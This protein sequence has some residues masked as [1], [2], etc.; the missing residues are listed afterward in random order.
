MG[1]VAMHMF[2]LC[3]F[4]LAGT[5]KCGKLDSPLRIID[6][7]PADM[8]E[9]PWMVLIDPVGCGGALI[10]NQWILTAAHCVHDKEKA[11]KAYLGLVLKST[12][13][14]SVVRNIIKID[15]HPKYGYSFPYDIA[16]IK[17]SEPVDNIR[18]I[19][20]PTDSSQDYVGFRATATGWGRTLDE[21]Y[22]DKLQEN[23]NMEVITN[24]RCQY[25]WHGVTNAIICAIVP[26]KVGGTCEG[27]SGGP[28]IVKDGRNYVLIGVTCTGLGD[29][30]DK[31]HISVFSR[32]T[33]VLEWINDRTSPYC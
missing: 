18:P 25:S 1:A 29:C 2:I 21:K 3:M 31:D 22:P 13:E 26:G 27:D 4:L 15:L 11:Y 32:V 16:L 5:G 14:Q 10:S 19:C 33:S 9:Y 8:D 17:M 6:G 23:T 12:K 24:A 20:L 30:A 28:L 7:Q